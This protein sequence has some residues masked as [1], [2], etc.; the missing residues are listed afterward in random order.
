[1]IRLSNNNNAATNDK[2]SFETDGWGT[3]SSEVKSSLSIL[4]S[5]PAMGKTSFA[6]QIACTVNPEVPFLYISNE[7]I[8]NKTISHLTGISIDKIK[9][10][11]LSIEESNAIT[12]ANQKLKS[13][14]LNVLE[15]V[16]LTT[17]D[18]LQTIRQAIISKRPKGVIIDGIN[19]RDFKNNQ[20]TQNDYIEYFNELK[21]I[22]DEY[23]IDLLV[24]HELDRTVEKKGNNSVPDL[25]DLKN[26]AFL[27]TITEN[28]F[29]LYRPEYYG[30]ADYYPK[31][32]YKHII[33]VTCFEKGKKMPSENNLFEINAN[34]NQFTPLQP[35]S[36]SIM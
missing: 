24:L 7:N 1:M 22:A 14:A 13:M 2:I 11:N 9:T 27:T 3:N 19:W 33:E 30:L 6:I 35:D 16:Q 4:S 23:Q 18:S 5:R 25:T 21:S 12:N 26:E 31:F 29:F 10:N 15:N 8:T 36:C 20:C 34:F 17:K 28:I 32:K